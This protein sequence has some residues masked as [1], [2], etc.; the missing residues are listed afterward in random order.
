MSDSVKEYRTSDL[1]EASY[2]VTCGFPVVDILQAPQD[3]G[4]CEFI[5]TEEAT[6]A[7]QDYY[8]GAKAEAQHL[9]M[10]LREL[11]G[12]LFRVQRQLR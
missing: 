4:R 6:Q 11:K 3:P 10:N 7:G 2:I 12:R 1:G 8:L 9:T 5:F